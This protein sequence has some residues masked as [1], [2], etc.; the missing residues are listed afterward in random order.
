MHHRTPVDLPEVVREQRRDRVPVARGPGRSEALQRPHR[1]GSRCGDST[2]APPGRR[3][4]RAFPTRARRRVPDGARVPQLVQF[5]EASLGGAVVVEV[6]QLDA[7][8][9][10]PVVP[11]DGDELVLELT[12][13]DRSG[14]GHHRHRGG[15][16]QVR[17]VI[18]P[19]SA[20][21]PEVVEAPARREC[22]ARP[23]GASKP[24]RRRWLARVKSSGN[25]LATVS[26]S[27]AA[28]ARR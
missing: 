1:R 16:R 7:V 26:Q 12:P 22:S 15:A 23:I 21:Q 24:T 4:P 8:H 3:P 17:E 13:A 18:E 25:S 11:A 14:P 19:L 27:R 6:E 28:D 20:L 9:A 10:L 5:R 2:P